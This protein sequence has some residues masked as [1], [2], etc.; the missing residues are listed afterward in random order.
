MYP[1]K[2]FIDRNVGPAGQYPPAA[3]RPPTRISLFCTAAG[4]PVR[5]FGKQS[6]YRGSSSITSGNACDEVV[7]KLNPKLS[8]CGF[9]GINVLRSSIMSHGRVLG[10]PSV[11]SVLGNVEGGKR[12][13]GGQGSGRAD[14]RR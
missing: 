5:L 12:V 14:G 6:L 1:Q 11:D 10:L 4:D 9:E 13:G 8:E 2:Q 3:T 7:R